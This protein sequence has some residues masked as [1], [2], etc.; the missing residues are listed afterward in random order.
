MAKLFNQ[1]KF[2]GMTLLHAHAQ[3]IYIVNA[4]YQKPS[5]KA[6]LQVDF[7]VY[8]Q[9]KSLFKSKQEKN[10]SFQKAVILSKKHFFLA[11]NFFMQMF[12]ES[13]LCRQS[14]QLF[15]HKLWY[16]LNSPHMHYLYT[17]YKIAKL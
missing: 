12:N 13:I 11:S 6:M 10:G 1:K 9:A 4:K 14:T 5:V 16:K 2:F 3:Y 15:R 7:L 8:A 17:S